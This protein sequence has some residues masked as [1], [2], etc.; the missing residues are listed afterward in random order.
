MLAL[1]H[2]PWDSPRPPCT[3]PSP[4]RAPRPGHIPAKGASIH[5]QL[6]TPETWKPPRPAPLLPF[7]P[8]PIRP[9]VPEVFPA[10]LLEL[11]AQLP[12]SLGRGLQLGREGYFS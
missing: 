12:L 5:T 10:Q 11:L 6:L 7:T 8:S 4:P 9:W 3:Q 2:L 1:G